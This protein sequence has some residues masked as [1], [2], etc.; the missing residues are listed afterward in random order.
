MG[1]GKMGLEGG[2]FRVFTFSE[3]FL[4]IGI[5]GGCGAGEI[6]QRWSVGDGGKAN[7]PSPFDSTPW[8]ENGW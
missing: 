5:M 1:V 2:G 7:Y 4:K 8:L 6:G 3:S